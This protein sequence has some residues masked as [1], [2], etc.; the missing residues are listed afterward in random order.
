MAW[1]TAEII[2]LI[3][4]ILNNGSL[5]IKAVLMFIKCFTSMYRYKQTYGTWYQFEMFV[6]PINAIMI[7]FVLT[8][9]FIKKNVNLVWSIFALSAFLKTWT[10]YHILVKTMDAL[11]STRF[12]RR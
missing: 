4:D 8:A 12:K 7:I 11:Y 1:S 9:V 6:F 5:L 10:S 2:G 3:F